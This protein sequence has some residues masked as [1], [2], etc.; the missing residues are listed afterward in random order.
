MYVNVGGAEQWIQI[1]GD[2]PD[3]PVLLFL[4]C[5]PGGSTRMAAVA[6]KSWERY[7]TVVHWGQ[8]GAGKTFARNGAQRCGKLTLE[9]MIADGIEVAEF[10]LDHLRQD[11]IILVG[12]SWDSALGTHIVKRRSELFSAY[13]TT[14]VVVNSLR[15]EA[16]NHG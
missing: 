14:W 16:F 3:N 13:L 5:G 4:H 10:L 8:R 2:N 11:K 6:W 15:S 12:H 1:E 9:R 7:L